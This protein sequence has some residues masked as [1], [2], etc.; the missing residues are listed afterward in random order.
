MALLCTTTPSAPTEIR[1]PRTKLELFSVGFFWFGSSM[2]AKCA[3]EQPMIRVPRRP[4]TRLPPTASLDDPRLVV[5]L[6]AKAA[7]STL[8][9]VTT[10][11]PRTWAGPALT[12]QVP[13]TITREWWPAS[14]PGDLG[15]PEQTNAPPCRA[16]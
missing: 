6:S 16:G 7:S 8:P 2:Q 9:A 1:L 3:A 5:S 12:A 10:T 15:V 13:T 11:L 4:T 14:T